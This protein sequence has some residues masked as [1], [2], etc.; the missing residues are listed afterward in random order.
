[1]HSRAANRERGVI[2]YTLYSRRNVGRH[3]VVDRP[4]LLD[5]SKTESKL[6]LYS[7]RQVRRVDCDA[8]TADSR[9]R[10]KGHV[11]VRLRRGGRERV[12]DI[13]AER[14]RHGGQL[15][16]ERDVDLPERILDEL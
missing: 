14:M 10:P 13:D 2:E 16:H 4:R 8:V 15:V 1:M 12:P 3:A 7:P 11:S 9:P 5:E 6:A